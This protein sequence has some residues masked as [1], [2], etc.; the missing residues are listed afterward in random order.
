MDSSKK[1]F[2]LRALTGAVGAALF[3][4]GLCQGEYT[5]T[6]N[7]AVRICLECIGIG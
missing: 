6:L 2:V 1:V 4:M 5:V 7:K 3:I